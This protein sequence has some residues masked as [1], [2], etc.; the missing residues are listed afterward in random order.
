MAHVLN[1][2]SFYV[3]WTELLPDCLAQDTADAVTNCM[4]DIWC[5]LYHKSEAFEAGADP[6]S[7]NINIKPHDISLAASAVMSEKNLYTLLG[8]KN[9][10]LK[11]VQELARRFTVIIFQ[12]CILLEQQLEIEEIE[13]EHGMG[14]EDISFDF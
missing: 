8:I 7:C 3:H 6:I 13:T 9:C 14:V 4:A 2:L 11:Q 10:S 1:S 12:L 5:C